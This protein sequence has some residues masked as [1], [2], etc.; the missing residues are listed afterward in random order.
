MAVKK[1]VKS[2]FSKPLPP[3]EAP[4]IVARATIPEE[5]GCVECGKPIH[6]G[7]T[8]VCKDHVRSN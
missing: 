5:G 3:S 6:E 7:Q 8:Y 4:P 2:F 1:T